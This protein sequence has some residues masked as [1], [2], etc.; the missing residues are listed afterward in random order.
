METT[1][2]PADRTTGGYLKADFTWYGLDEAF[3]GDRWLAPVGMSADGTVEH[4]STG[5]GDEPSVKVEPTPDH[6][7]F[8]VVVTVADRPVRRSSDGTGVLDATSVASAAWLAGSGLLTCTWPTQMERHLRQ[9]WLDQQ[10]AIA[11]DLADNLEG[12]D[13]SA[14]SLPVDGVPTPFHYR[15]SEYGWV[16]AGSARG[17]H[18]GAFGR[19]MSAYG[20][21]LA[22]V[23]D[24]TMYRP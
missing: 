14:L 23:K 13:W 10:T 16:M 17:V 21:G 24:I 8:V 22:Q 18:L 1:A 4:G 3:T 2:D 20:L 12:P 6:R 5:H 9:N 15:E 7:R 19:G 11:W